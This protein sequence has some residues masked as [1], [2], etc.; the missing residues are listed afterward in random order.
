MG[1]W[2]KKQA[3]GNVGLWRSKSS[4]TLLTRHNTPLTLTLA[5]GRPRCDAMGLG[6]TSQEHYDDDDD[7]HD[8]IDDENRAVW[9]VA[10]FTGGGADRNAMRLVSHGP[11]I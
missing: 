5:A 7:D 3:A 9:G 11:H 8:S 4:F 6:G 10:C 2:Q 1:G